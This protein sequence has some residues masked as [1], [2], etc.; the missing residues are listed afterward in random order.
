MIY[1]AEANGNRFR[2]TSGHKYL[3]VRDGMGA[4]AH[5]HAL[6]V[7]YVQQGVWGEDL[8]DPSFPNI[9]HERASLMPG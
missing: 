6:P 3:V 7:L 8:P 4:G 9:V 2:L 5:G 1:Q